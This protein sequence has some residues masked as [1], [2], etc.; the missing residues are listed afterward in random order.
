[1]TESKKRIAYKPI[2]NYDD[3]A[4]ANPILTAYIIMQ[5]DGICPVFH[6]REDNIKELTEGFD[7]IGLLPFPT[8]SEACEVLDDFDPDNDN[9]IEDWA[10]NMIFDEEG[11]EELRIALTLSW[12][13]QSPLDLKLSSATSRRTLSSATKETHK[14]GR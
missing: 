14:Q 1:M 9:V 6:G 2:I 5:E 3:N 4:G 11:S 7:E 10:L 13:Q 8:P 12:K